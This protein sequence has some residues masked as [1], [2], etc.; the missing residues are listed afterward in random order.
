LKRKLLLP[1]VLIGGAVAVL[2]VLG[3]HRESRRQL[4]RQVRQR[5][6][7]VANMVN[8]A[9]ESVSRSGELQRL[10]TAT[11]A[12][13]DLLE[14]VVAG[15]QP[16]RVLAST[17]SVWLGQRLGELP[18]RDLADDLARTIQLRT[19]QQRFNAAGHRFVFASPLILSPAA[20]ADGVL[21]ESAVVVHVDTRPME[22]AVR[23]ASL[24][25]SAIF[26]GGLALLVVLGYGLLSR[27]VLRPISA[28]GAALQRD[29]A[30]AGESWSAAATDDELGLLAGAL[31][32]SRTRTDGAL[33][34][35]EQQKEALLA[36]KQS[37]E[38]ANR[39]KSDF[40]ANM[41]HE[42]RT[43]MNGVIG[44]AN[45]L[46]ATELNPRQRHYGATIRAS[47]ES[48]L[49]VIS[50]ILDF[51]KMEAGKL[52][53]ESADFDLRE[54]VEQTIGLLSERAHAKKLEL[55]CLI[56]NEVPAQLRGD[57][58]RLRQV[59][60]NLVSNAIKFTASG[61]V[62]VRVA[63]ESETESHAT[64]RFAVS[65]T[66]IGIPPE[67]RRTLFHSFSQGDPSITRKYG[68]TGLGLAISRQLTACMGGEIG[69]ESEVGKGSTFWFTVRLAKP[70]ATAPAASAP[71]AGLAGLR[72]LVVDDN[73][74]NRS[75]LEHQLTAWQIRYTSAADGFQALLKLHQAAT[76][77]APFDL[78][79]LD[80]QMPFLD[81]L[82]LARAI[83][84]EPT[85]S[86]TRLV[87]LTSV[88]EHPDEETQ[89]LAGLSA[90]LDKPVRQSQLYACLTGAGKRPAAAQP[91]PDAPSPASAE[92]ESRVRILLA[93]DNVINQEVALGQL[94]Q[95]GYTADIVGNGR[96]AL[97][98][99]ARK[100]YDLVLMDCQMPEL[101]G[102][103]ATAQ[104]REREHAFAASGGKPARLP[105]IA[106]TANVMP[107]DRAKCLAAGMDD[108][109]GKPVEV[110]Q[111]KAAIARALDGSPAEPAPAEPAPAGDDVDLR[112]LNQ[113]AGNNPAQRRKLLHLY[114]S[115]TPRQ[116][117]ALSAAIA[118]N[119]V[120][121]V[122]YIVHKTSG[123]SLSLGF[124]AMAQPLLRLR[125]MAEQDHLDDGAVALHRELTAH[126]ERIKKQLAA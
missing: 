67:I 68:G 33:A 111:L 94:E 36:A 122:R 81:G 39:A 4:E 10:V 5:A 26:L 59:L 58:N 37:A 113:A 106:M 71:P 61:E 101:D 54:S 107:H 123:S 104:I 109:V 24:E 100:T 87:M 38:E 11:G 14:I 17:K 86:A 66:G 49:G 108:Y 40:L 95:L 55:A 9:A 46:L 120:T 79:I 42:I 124:T 112:R 22:A 15:G 117:E 18:G 92:E 25:F 57:P 97:A 118:E 85:L 110:A 27:V 96:E 82:K 73:V 16:A 83:T 21:A 69:V 80:M 74:T 65:D 72:V 56:Y 119:R 115:E 32:D 125:E 29:G 90:C 78:A 88:A 116:L 89:R 13:S 31:R 121:D 6:E 44:M 99:L 70:A 102:Y 84:A 48:L 60:T 23:Q 28:I 93:E 64:L 50:D 63:R 34:E 103:S 30:E 51:S 35:L 91:M 114:F 77:G 2:A 8:Y 45:L 1:L 7:L 126:L 12:E 47:A 76:D 62:V 19:P 105:I 41:S 43:P 3:I 53:F 20:V 98:A 52:H 75:I